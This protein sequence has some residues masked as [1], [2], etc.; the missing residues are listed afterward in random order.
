MDIKHKRNNYSIITKNLLLSKPTTF[1]SQQSTDILQ[2]K[3]L[4]NHELCII[5]NYIAFEKGRLYT[6]K[7]KLNRNIKNIIKG[8][9]QTLKILSKLLESTNIPMIIIHCILFNKIIWL[10]NK[11]ISYCIKIISY[12]MKIIDY[13]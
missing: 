12:C 11:I 3:V 8:S 10:L 9:T 4:N 7:I 2:L 13:Q 6:I 1:M 5:N